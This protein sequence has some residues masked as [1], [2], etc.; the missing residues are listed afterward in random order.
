MI[1]VLRQAF[2][3]DSRTL[4]VVLFLGNLTS[5]SL[6][7]SYQVTNLQGIDYTLPRT[8]SWGKILQ[9]C[10]YLLFILR[11][12][13][14]DFISV[15]IGNISL[16]SGF[17]FEAM[18]LLAITNVETRRHR[19]FIR[20]ISAI[21]IIVF[22]AIE[23][24]YSNPS[25]RVI[26]SSIGVFATIA[27]PCLFLLKDKN[28][29]RFKKMVGVYYLIC[30]SVLLPR[31][32]Y[33]IFEP[34]TDIFTNAVLHSLTFL[35]LIMLLI[36]SLASYLLLTKEKT[37][38]IVNMLATTDHLSG[39]L[40]RKSFFDKAEQEFERIKLQTKSFSVLF[41]DLDYFKK[42]NDTYGHLIGD[43][44]IRKTSEVLQSC[45]R[46]QDLICRYGG[47][48]FAVF[49]PLSSNTAAVNISKRIMEKI[50]LIEV[51]AMTGFNC[52]ISIGIAG[53]VPQEKEQLE[54]YLEMADKALYRAKNTGRNRYVEYA[55][56]MAEEHKA[57]RA[58]L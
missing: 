8:F 46:S 23:H 25:Y 9:A 53:G 48:E 12:N 50:R 28:V 44:V 38:I 22:V 37:D 57:E 45:V 42:I 6:I 3:L 56:D 5:V 33:T 30:L 32:F 26:Y 4:V 29:N 47:E 15:Y 1:E 20:L 49:L 2:L 54:D 52:S 39:L 41:C 17:Y 55:P 34:A 10:A 27:L 11:E 7:A 21:S 16:L 13:I 51:E 14:P 19:F 31:I 18:A 40:N 24:V 36:F 35:S 43:E 58:A